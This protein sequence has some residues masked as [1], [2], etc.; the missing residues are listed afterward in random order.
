MWTPWK[1]EG[2]LG[3]SAT[4]FPGAL[5]RNP[6]NG[7][8]VGHDQA[9][10]STRAHGAGVRVT[11]RCQVGMQPLGAA[12]GQGGVE[13]LRR[14]AGAEGGRAGSGLPGRGGG[15]AGGSLPAT[16]AAAR[17]SSGSRRAASAARGMT[18]GAGAER[19]ASRKCGAPPEP[20]LRAGPAGWGGEGPR[21]GGPPGADPGSHIP[22]ARCLLERLSVI[23]KTFHLD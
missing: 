12:L 23:S 15:A 4:P 20:S 22:L 9:P 19:G 5:S 11:A 18:A 2:S 14:R 10:G 21:G 6:L 1:R 7:R 8:R 3:S 13:S 16:A 17:P